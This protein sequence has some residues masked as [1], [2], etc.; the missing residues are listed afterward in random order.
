MAKRR[1]KALTRMQKLLHSD[2]ALC[3]TFVNTEA[4]GRGAIESYDDLLAW[5]VAAGALSATEAERLAAAAA[6]HPGNAAGAVRRALT[7]RQ[8][9]RRILLALA[10]GER[11]AATDFGPF[12]ADLGRAMAA[13]HLAAT[14][15]GY[16]WAWGDAGG[17]DLDRMLWPV[18]LSAAELLTSPGRQRVGQCAGEDCGLF[19]AARNSGRPRRWCGVACRT[20]HSSEKHYRLRV[21]PR[22]ELERSS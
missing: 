13:R 12:D 3:V 18:L 10:E 21:K 7:L 1:R 14:P 17:E 8:R 5:G 9:L 15:G 11:P 19:F 22:R 2:G 16:R 4:P 20:R 6:E